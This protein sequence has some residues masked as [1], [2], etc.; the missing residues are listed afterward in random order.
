[1]AW[2]EDPLFVVNTKQG[3][4]KCHG[5]RRARKKCEYCRGTGFEPI[6]LAGLWSPQPGFLVCGGPSLS[7]L[8]LDALRQR[9]VVSVG[10][11]NAGAYAPCTAMTFGDPQYKFHSACFFDPKCITFAPTGKLRRTVRIKHKGAFRFTNVRLY[12]CP[13]VF[14]IARRGSFKA[15]T[16]L[17]TYFAHWGHGGQTDSEQPFRRLATMLLGIRLLH[18]LGC[19]RIYMIGVDFSI[20]TDKTKPG[21]AWGDNA[22]AG[23]KIWWKIDTMMETL[24]PVFAEAGVEVFNCNPESNSKAF[25]HVP[26]EKAIV[27]CRGPIETEPFDIA[28]WYGKK[29]MIVDKERHPTT[30]SWSGACELLRA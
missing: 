1:M 9:G 30:L 7:T 12:E 6:S 24:V 20:P 17:S 15:S 26:F 23:N 3:C 10:I 18:Y 4:V 11:N 28:D 13:N 25:P 8:P 27:D 2:Q 29:R 22:S 16:F 19:P 21:Y 14:G 5:N